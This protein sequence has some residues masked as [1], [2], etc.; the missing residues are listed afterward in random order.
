M[1]QL[2]KESGTNPLM[3]RVSR[4]FKSGLIILGLLASASVLTE[5]T[6]TKLEQLKELKGADI[7]F[8]TVAE[9]ERQLGCLAQNIY[10]EAGYEPFEG[11]VG[12]AQVTLNRAA[13]GN[14]PSDI[15]AVVYQKSVIYSKVICQFSWYCEQPSRMKPINNV[16]YAESMAVA[17]KVLL[18]GFKLDGLRNAMYY[19]ADYVNPQWGKEKVAKIGR[20][21]FYS[22]RPARGS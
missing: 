4:F 2:V 12:V 18:E 11:K 13:S 6:T 22:E 7:T 8:V 14:F 16:A 1:T 20:H 21:I 9:R 3:D 19:H 15:C 5:V 17:K 10:H